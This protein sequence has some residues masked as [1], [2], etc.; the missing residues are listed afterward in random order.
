MRQL[1]REKIIALSLIP[2]L[3]F[4]FYYLYK[5][6]FFPFEWEPTDG[7]H[8][9]FANRISEQLPIFFNLQ[10]GNILSVYNPLYHFLIAGADFGINQFILA[11]SISALFWILCSILIYFYFK[12]RTTRINAFLASITILFPIQSGLL[13]DM[14]QVTPVA[15]MVFLFLATIL[16]ADSIQTSKHP[17][18]LMFA[19]G[20]L[21]CFTFLAKQQGIIA[22]FVLL[23]YFLIARLPL[24]RVFIFIFASLF[25]YYLIAEL[26]S[27]VEGN[28]LIAATLTEVPSIVKTYWKLSIIRLFSFSFFNVLLI[29]LSVYVLAR[30]CVLKRISIWEV[31]LFMHIPFLL[32]ILKNGAGG[33]NYFTTFWISIVVVSCNLIFSTDSSCKGI[34]YIAK[35]GS[36][37]FYLN[38]KKKTKGLLY[39]LLSLS[40]L[41]G[42]LMF[43]KDVVKMNLPNKELKETMLNASER[44][45]LLT[46]QGKRIEMLTNRNIG[47]FLDQRIDIEN[48]GCSLFGAWVHLENFKKSILLE[49]IRGQKYDYIS[50]GFQPYP[51]DV[52]S[53]IDKYYKV[54]D[55]YPTNYY[56]GQIG[57]QSIYGPRTD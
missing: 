45:D 54:I 44:V 43:V 42:Q 17:T 56:F 7:D 10:S 1:N 51:E 34:P 9:N 19:L 5:I 23:G 32:F 26:I 35:L 20:I 57:I 15:L 40:I 3:V 41:L 53:A 28:F 52:Q 25:T 48:E 31:S 38:S 46:K 39:I 4:Y 22:F 13:V 49:K 16:L 55:S 33:S 18:L 50:T 12:R 29:L 14:V 6:V 37:N 27:L 8:V 47:V 11:R 36:L 21:S 30:N 24:K 2:G